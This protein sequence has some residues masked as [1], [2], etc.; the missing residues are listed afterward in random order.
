M[1]TPI[2]SDNELEIV[3]NSQ[4]AVSGDDPTGFDKIAIK[5]ANKRSN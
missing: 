4:D 5:F 2:E 3:C 1:G